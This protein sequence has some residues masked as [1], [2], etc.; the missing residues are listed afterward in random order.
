MFPLLFY[1]ACIR[2]SSGFLVDSNPSKRR[3]LGRVSPSILPQEMQF[4]QFV[5]HLQN[6]PPSWSLTTP[7]CEW[8]R[9]TCDA[10][11]RLRSV[12]WDAMDLRGNLSW[13]YLPPTCQCVSA[14]TNF[15]SGELLLGDLPYALTCS[16][17]HGQ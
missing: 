17:P 16:E 14:V 13:S 6:P 8:E 12:S 11:G 10:E 2:F 15:L 5:R 7:T 3:K 1:F 9:V 4:P